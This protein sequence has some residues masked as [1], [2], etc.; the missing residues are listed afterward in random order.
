MTKQTG[1]GSF[2]KSKGRQDKATVTELT[3][4]FKAV[5]CL[6]D[7]EQAV[8]LPGRVD[9]DVGKERKTGQDFRRVRVDIDF[10]K[11]RREEMSAEIEV[12]KVEKAKDSI[13]GDDSVEDT[14]KCGERSGVV[15]GGQE[16]GRRSPP[17]VLLTRRRTLLAS[18]RSGPGVRRE[19]GDHFSLTTL[20]K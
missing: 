15:E 12:N 5:H 6:V 3:S 14:V 18:E 16:E 8:P 7:P 4:F 20:L 17:T 9:L 13:F 19:R 11:L 10:Y 2:K 1:S